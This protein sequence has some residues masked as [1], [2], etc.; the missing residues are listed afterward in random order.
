MARKEKSISQSAGY[1][2]LIHQRKLPLLT[3][4][5][6]W[7]GIFPEGSKP[8]HIKKIEER[9]NNEI[10]N[11]SKVNSEFKELKKLK[12]NLMSGIVNNMDTAK[13][14]KSENLRLKKM[15]KSKKLI[16]N[17]NV[18]L[19]DC[20]EKQYTIP[21]QIREINEQLMLATAENCYSRIVNNERELKE[22]TEWI[23]KTRVELKKRLLIKQE[24][25]EINEKMYHYLHNMLG[26]EFM[27]AFDSDHEKNK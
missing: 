27:E 8:A 2:K 22:L 17:I 18:K 23:D 7:H 11:Q 13:D 10:K 1:E 6:E 26:P 25:E 19:S 14:I 4:D 24:L 16:E 21:E 20:E 12:Q 5:A 9:L 15:E 3:L